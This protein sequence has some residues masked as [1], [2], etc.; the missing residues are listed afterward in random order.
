VG[1]GKGTATPPPPAPF[2]LPYSD[3]FERGTL[4]QSAKYF[5]DQDGAF[6]VVACTGRPGHCLRQVV[7]QHPI[8]WHG[9]SPDP[10]TF[11]GSAD[12]SDYQVST[13][14][15]IE[16]SGSVTLAGRIDSADWFQDEK[17]RWVSGYIL[18]VQHDGTWDLDS[19]RFKAAPV[20]LASGKLPFS[21]KTW[22]HLTLIFRGATIQASID[23]ASVANLT[24]TSH[25]KGMAG[26]GTGWN[27][28]QFDN[29]SIR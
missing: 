5:A 29:F 15:M 20:K 24:D 25:K 21:L 4:G 27:T 3:D 26:I 9:M 8:A 13:D 11:L 19:T 23:G 28:A 17:A 2:P 16:E 14:A 22:H 7:D 18:S 1:Q 12:W 6:E 10:F